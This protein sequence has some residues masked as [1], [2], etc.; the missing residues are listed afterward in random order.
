VSR[1]LVGLA[2]ALF[3]LAG[4]APV[5]AMLARVTP[6]DLE[7]LL[8]AR[9]L[10]LLG[11]T[12]GYGLGVA[13]LALALGV[14]FG[15]LVART[16][17]PL[18]SALR[19]LGLVP[20]LFP[21][22][23]LAMVWTAAAGIRG[24]AAACFV[25]A[26]GTFPLVALF[27]ARAFERVDGR[28]EDAARLCGGI[29]AVLRCDLP[30]VLPSA[31]CG[32][33]FAFVF[34]VN[35]FSVPDYVSWVGAPKFNV[36]ADEIFA[37]W[38]I[39]S[40]PGRAVATALPLVALTLA[41]LVPALALR[42]K[43]AM[44]SLG[45]DFRQPEPLALG[46]W[47]WPAFAFCLAL[48]ALGCGVPVARLA[49]EAG[50]GPKGFEAARLAESFRLAIER[51]R[52]DLR[53]SIVWA[54]AAASLCAAAGLVI[55]HALERSRRGRWLEPLVLVPLAVP[56]ILLGI[57]VIVLWNHDATARFYDGPGAAILLLAG[58]F[59]PFPILIVSGAVAALDP[60]LEEA[61]RLAGAGPAERLA[62]IVAPALRSSV[63]GG[64][65]LV[66]V[67]ALRELDATILVPAANHTAMFRIFNQVHFGRDAF[68]AA[69]ALLLVFLI[70][71]PGLAWSL[72]ARRRLE[73]L[74]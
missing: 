17:L 25:S 68:V 71:L 72:F 23:I 61:A 56:A 35:D 52:E 15:F 64:W 28:Q 5:V 37:T 58:R 39:D 34:T 32:A 18:A 45:A 54:L 30:L 13:A 20:L 59:A 11:R 9:T 55:G 44:A 48:L 42:R 41:T 19:P 46:R 60:R 16:D 57:G 2:L 3:A 1:P 53:N 43:G 10:A 31:L 12:L 65:V 24:A 73:L 62:R 69:M 40:S 36:Y 6:G 22:M 14:P 38:R 74:P 70:A 7:G 33:C 50:G 8:A 47:K 26:I 67:L 4:L 27:T 63:A 51:S 29:G 21:P 49:W 66:F